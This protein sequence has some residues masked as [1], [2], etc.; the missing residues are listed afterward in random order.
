[1]SLRRTLASA[2][3]APLL[4]VLF[5]V[6]PQARAAVLDITNGYTSVLLTSAGPLLGLGIGVA[7]LGGA[8]VAAAAP[9]LPP[10]AT[11]PI[12]GNSLDL[13]S[14]VG[15][16][17]HD[18]SGLALTKGT[19]TVAL[20]DFLVDTSAPATLFGKV[21]GG[22]PVGLFDV[23]VF[24]AVQMAPTVV[25]ALSRLTLTAGAASALENAFGLSGLTGF[26]IG[27]ASTIATLVPEPA[28]YAMLGLG[29]L[30]IGALRLRRRA[31]LA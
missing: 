11:F 16:I 17:A 18:G 25:G 9:G 5:F 15:Q 4:A 20:T 10:T 19:T 26:E 13:P 7:P 23:Q 29:L 21:N 28:T 22:G 8:T 30:A 27:Y 3:A 31:H 2:L 14:F 6:G 12:T 1:M 24:S